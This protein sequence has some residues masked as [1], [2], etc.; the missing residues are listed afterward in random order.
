LKQKLADIAQD[1]EAAEEL[2]ANLGTCSD[3]AAYAY[4]T[5]CA[6]NSP[7]RTFKIS[8][9]TVENCLLRCKMDQNCQ[10]IS[11]NGQTCIGCAAEPSEASAGWTTYKV[12]VDEY[13]G[14]DSIHVG[15]GSGGIYAAWRAIDSGVIDPSK[16]CIFEYHDRIGGRAIAAEGYG[17]NNDMFANVGAYRYYS[18][19]PMEAQIIETLLGFQAE[20][21]EN[22]NYCPLNDTVNG[23][24]RN[25]IDSETGHRASFNAWQ[26]KL[27]DRVLELGGRL[28]LQRE[29]LSISADETTNMPLE[30]TFRNR[31]TDDIF[32]LTAT[33][34]FLNLP[35]Q[36]LRKVIYNEDTNLPEGQ[37]LDD[38]FEIVQNTEH[39]NAMKV[40]LWYDRAWWFEMGKHSGTFKYDQP[41]ASTSAQ[42][43]DFRYA[44]PNGR[45]HDGD[46]HCDSEDECYGFLL[47]IYDNIMDFQDDG[48]VYGALRNFQVLQKY[49][50]DITTPLH[51]IDRSKKP[52]A[53]YMDML[54]EQI[55]KMIDESIDGTNDTLAEWTEVNGNVP[56]PTKA[57]I[58]IWNEATDGINIGWGLSNVVE[59]ENGGRIW[60]SAQP[61]LTTKLL[62]PFSGLNIH[63]MNEAYSDKKTW[64]EGS[65]VMA[66]RI[67]MEAYGQDMASFLEGC[68]LMG[69]DSDLPG[70]MRCPE[71]TGL[72]NI[73]NNGLNHFTYST[74]D[75]VGG[76]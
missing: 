13:A 44:S 38:I 7:D 56:L 51:E 8:L 5:K 28:F 23:N 9:T 59:H 18:R 66:E 24:H 52:H 41:I 6:F 40:Y 36:P 73:Q 65:L 11:T 21:Y 64:S 47:A 2:A 57:A 55:M 16:V 70:Q 74:A 63:F 31:T 4:D 30:M 49:I 37:G 46:V 15:A 69:L 72:E 68:V 26:K 27:V 39:V 12:E 45:W 35:P 71:Y 3:D 33:H 29:L 61:E 1:V 17:P 14:C 76:R 32:T 50:G 48:L 19:S 25:I 10:Y 54:H 75:N 20:C 42:P 58:G 67:F 43:I 62:K 22:T 34:A 53:Q 60:Q